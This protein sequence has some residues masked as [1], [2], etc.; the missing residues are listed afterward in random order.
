[1]RSHQSK[2]LNDAG[3]KITPHEPPGRIRLSDL[4][5]TPE[6]LNDRLKCGTVKAVLLAR[7]CYKHHV[8][9]TEMARL[10]EALK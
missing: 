2:S 9:V 10:L 6:W 5:E 7:F 3:P 8:P 1:M 4:G